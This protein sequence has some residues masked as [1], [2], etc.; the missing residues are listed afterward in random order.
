[1]QEFKRSASSGFGLEIG[2]RHRLCAPT[3]PNEPLSLGGQ[4]R[5]LLGLWMTGPGG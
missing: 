3:H 5:G 2:L 4:Q 1:M